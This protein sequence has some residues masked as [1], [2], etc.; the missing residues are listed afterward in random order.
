MVW[1]ASLGV[2]VAVMAMKKFKGILPM[3][4]VGALFML[5][6]LVLG[7][8]SNKKMMG[9]LAS[10]MVILSM[11]VVLPKQR[12][13]CVVDGPGYALLFPFAWVVLMVAN[14]KMAFM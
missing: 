14:N 1:G 5:S 13:L 6:W 7:Y 11:V 4:V 9:L 8:A 10:L 3:P 2:V 12:E